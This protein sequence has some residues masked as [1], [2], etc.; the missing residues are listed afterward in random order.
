[1]RVLSQGEADA[2]SGG[3]TG[4]ALG[5]MAEIIHAGGAS[6]FMV[7]LSFF[8]GVGAG[9]AFNAGWTAMTGSTFGGSIYDATH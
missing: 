4:A 6:I 8:A 9:M 7:G 3:L 2:V 5:E 1:M